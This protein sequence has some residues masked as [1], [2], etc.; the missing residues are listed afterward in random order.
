MPDINPTLS[1]R[2]EVIYDGKQFYVVGIKLIDSPLLNNKVM[3]QISPDLPSIH[4]IGKGVYPNVQSVFEREELMTL[5]EYDTYR[6]AELETASNAYDKTLT[7]LPVITLS[8]DLIYRYVF[9]G[10][11]TFPWDGASYPPYDPLTAIPIGTIWDDLGGVVHD[12]EDG[13]H[14]NELIVGQHIGNIIWNNVGL[15]YSIDN[16]EFTLHV[17]IY[18]TD[19]NDVVTIVP[20]IDLS[21]I[22]EYEIVYEIMDNQRIYSYP[23]SRFV[24]VHPI[25]E[26]PASEC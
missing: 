9:D 13:G 23:V 18:H 16:P 3:Y 14:G 6:I 26:P 25:P 11:E 22:G 19:E 12:Q 5:T 8:G 1:L 24:E 7:G 2:D 17:V 21:I 10:T 20:N 15:T 4:G